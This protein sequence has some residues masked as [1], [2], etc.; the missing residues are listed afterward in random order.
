L[1]VDKTPY[2]PSNPYGEWV[3]A[4]PPHVDEDP[5]DEE[6][7]R[8]S[9]KQNHED[10]DEKWAED[11]LEDAGNKLLMKLKKWWLTRFEI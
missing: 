7:T 10:E 9:R 6:P 2:D 1:T 4:S 8:K 11:V 5:N 3:K